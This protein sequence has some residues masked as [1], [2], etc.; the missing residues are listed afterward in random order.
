[1]SPSP[2][3]YYKATSRED[4]TIQG[5]E[6]GRWRLPLLDF[7]KPENMHRDKSVPACNPH[8]KRA[9]HGGIEGERERVLTAFKTPLGILC[10]C[11]LSALLLAST[12]SQHSVR[13]SVCKPLRADQS[14]FAASAPHFLSPSA[15]YLPFQLLFFIPLSSHPLS[16]LIPS[17][18]CS[19]VSG[20][21]QCS[22]SY[23]S[24]VLSSPS[25]ISF[26]FSRGPTYLLPASHSSLTHRRRRRIRRELKLVGS[27]EVTEAFGKE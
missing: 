3:V 25:S 6:G 4:T 18:S 22:T 11:I 16:P 27:R 5:A 23:S 7:K 12:I 15:F 8:T 20:L 1:M 17:P 13:L 2:A 14:P 9:R 24:L 21:F 10:H 26:L 19:G